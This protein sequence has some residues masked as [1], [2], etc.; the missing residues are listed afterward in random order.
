[1]Q[2]TVEHDVIGGGGCELSPGAYESQGYLV[3]RVEVRGAFDLFQLVPSTAARAIGVDLPVEGDPF[4]VDRTVA[5]AK[6]LELRLHASF[7]DSE[8]P[9]DVTLVVSNIENCS[10]SDGRKLLDVRYRT[11]T[12]HLP[13]A[14][15]LTIESRDAQRTDPAAAAGMLTPTRRLKLA[16]AAAYNASDGFQ[17]G[18]TVSVR[19]V[20]DRIDTLDAQ[21]IASNRS[22]LLRF[23]MSGSSAPHLTWLDTADWHV[24]IADQDEAGSPGDQFSTNALKGQFA[25]QTR[26]FGGA[27]TLFR[28]GGSLEGGHQEAAV[29]S[30]GTPVDDHT[31][32]GALRAAAGI[33]T[34]GNRYSAAASYG[35][36]LGHVPGESAV[37]YSKQIADFAWE[38]QIPVADHIA[39]QLEA[40]V[41]AGWLLGA[42]TAPR[43]EFFRG[44]NREESFLE[45]ESW[46]IRS[47]PFLRSVPSNQLDRTSPDTSLG[48][49]RFVAMNVTLSAPVWRY[50]LIPLWLS[51][52]ESFKS[53]IAAARETG[54]SQAVVYYQSKDPAQQ[55]MAADAA[56][57][58][59]VL[60]TLFDGLT[61]ARNSV[62]AGHQDA[63]DDCLDAADT[64]RDKMTHLKDTGF[65][66]IATSVVPGVTKGCVAELEAALPATTL[67]TRLDELKSLGASIAEKQKLVR[68]DLA[69]ARADEDLKFA[70]TAMDT[71]INDINAFAVGPVVSFDAARIGPQ[72]ADQAG[73]TRYGIGLGVRVSIVNVLHLTTLYAWNPSPLPWES[74]GA[75]MMTLTI[76]DL[77][78]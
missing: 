32:Y 38:S 39:L 70:F 43:A 23:A 56:K 71:F 5:A 59:T 42:N 2:A 19:N 51:R 24:S 69:Q 73:G 40:R 36:L 37:S 33:A 61:A 44:G 25:A 62:D 64:A 30:N 13:E 48:G 16:P 45:G 29:T 66:P 52:S 50:P 77:L 6:A 10:D 53:G 47:N 74:H 17:A 15:G 27:G 55:L 35:V 22:H 41:N 34:G 9:F 60:D 78:R 28:F 65:G 12:S 7:L 68:T 26:P 4:H 72:E 3:R 18:G 31:G 8:S 58:T 76:S 67:T 75:W 49:E 14:R 54:R 11:F 46:I 1:M 20:T 21:A 57:V 63:L